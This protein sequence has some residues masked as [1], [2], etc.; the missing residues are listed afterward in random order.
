M[1]GGA[2]D[3]KVVKAK[4]IVQM[5]SLFNYE[6]TEKTRLLLAIMHGGYSMEERSKSKPLRALPS[7]TKRTLNRTHRPS[8]YRKPQLHSSHAKI[9]GALSVRSIVPITAFFSPFETL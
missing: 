6:R 9:S 3:G 1:C 2:E 7:T 4:L 8:S 5:D